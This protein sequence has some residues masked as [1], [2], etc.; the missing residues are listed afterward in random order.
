M[1]P[2]ELNTIT[3]ESISP[4]Q[5]KYCD[6]PHWFDSIIILG[7]LNMFRT[8][9]KFMMINFGSIYSLRGKRTRMT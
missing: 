6:D 8:T 4:V 2:T 1:L 3:D 9:V 5:L 7:L